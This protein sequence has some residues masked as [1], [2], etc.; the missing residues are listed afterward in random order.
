M[1]NILNILVE[2]YFGKNL[3]DYRIPNGIH[4]FLP[5]VN[6]SKVTMVKSDG[7]FFSSD[8]T[9]NFEINM[10]DLNSKLD[11]SKKYLYIIELNTPKGL[12]SSFQSIPKKVINLVNQDRCN[13]IIDYEHEGQFNYEEYGEWYNQN[14]EYLEDYVKLNNFYF[15]ISDL[16]DKSTLNR[17][18]KI[19]IVDSYYFLEQFAIDLKNINYKTELKDFDYNF[20]IR[21]IS[22]IDLTKKKKRFISYMRNCVKPHRMSLGCFFEYNN[23]WDNNNLSFLKAN[24]FLKE[25][26]FPDSILDEKYKDSYNSLVKDD[27]PIQIDTHNFKK[28]EL[29]HFSTTFAGNWEHYQETFLSVVSETLF[30]TEN[31]FL[32]EKIFKPIINLHPFIVMSSNGFLSKLREFGFKTFSPFINEHYDN[33]VDHKLRLENLFEELLRINKMSDDELLNWWKE[34]LP[35][36]EHN[37]KHLLSFSKNKTTKQ[38][39]LEDLYG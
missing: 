17:K 6:D 36:L 16:S 8:I 13:V 26:H 38:K 22:D 14:V 2:N 7:P 30:D 19:N 5:K 37:Q 27:I 35:I 15:I 11:D 33:I 21:D 12:Y 32:S 9:N 39:L 18:L 28:D 1:G 4:R 34:I 29:P 10:I 31:I 23:M 25:S 3:K 20:E 24:N